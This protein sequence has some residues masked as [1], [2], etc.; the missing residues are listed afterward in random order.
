ML[1]RSFPVRNFQRGR[2]LKLSCS[3]KKDRL[4]VV[5][6][7][8]CPQ[9]NQSESYINTSTLYIFIIQKSNSTTKMGLN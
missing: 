2:S 1:Q 4:I 7:Q 6:H 5:N 9:Q 3:K 8:L